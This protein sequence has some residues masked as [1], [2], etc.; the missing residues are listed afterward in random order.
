MR[1]K[2]KMK[3]TTRKEA[4]AFQPGFLGLARRLQPQPRPEA[5]LELG[6]VGGREKAH[7]LEDEAILNCGDLR[8][9]AAGHV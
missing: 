5:V 8:L 2:S 6:G 9:D 7:R 4:A 1:I 3:I